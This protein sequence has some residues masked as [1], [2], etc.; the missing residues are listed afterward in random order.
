M[1]TQQRNT[2][3]DA[4]RLLSM[5]MVVMHHILTHGGLLFAFPD[6]AMTGEIVR[7]INALVFCAVNVYAIITGY[8]MSMSSFKFS[9][10]LMLWLQTAATGLVIT[11]GFAFF[12][13]AQVITRLTPSTM[14][15]T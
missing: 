9:R 7:M 13:G 5:A 4:L 2:G 12:S 6:G 8:G 14:S 1:Q 11:A 3:L 15:S 10:W